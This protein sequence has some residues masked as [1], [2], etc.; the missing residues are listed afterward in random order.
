[1]KHFVT[2]ALLF[3]IGT[4]FPANAANPDH[5]RQLLDTNEC[6]RCDLR[7]ADLQGA[8]LQGADLTGANLFQ[9]N[10]RSADLRN[11]NLLMITLRQANLQSANLSQAV[12][13]DATLQNATLTDAVAIAIQAYSTNFYGVNATNANFE[14]AS[15]TN[16]NFG[17]AN[18]SGTNLRQA[19]LISANLTGAD[20]RTATLTDAN[21]ANTNLTEA[22]LPAW[23]WRDTTDHPWQNC[24]WKLGEQQ[25]LSGYP[26]GTFRPEN[27]VSR[28]EFAAMIRNAFPDAPTVRDATQFRDISSSYWGA[29]AIRTA[30]RTGFLSGYPGQVFR[31]NLNIPRVQV[32]VALASGLDLSISSNANRMLDRAFGQ[33]ADTIPDYAIP[34]T[35]AALE[36]HLV[37]KPLEAEF[38][39]NEPASRAEVAMSICQAR[40]QPGQVEQVPLQSLIQV[41]P[42]SPYEPTRNWKNAQL[43]HKIE[44]QEASVQLSHDGQ[45]LV[46]H[47][48]SN[49]IQVWDMETGELRQTI[50]TEADREV[51]AAAASPNGETVAGLTRSSDGRS[52]FLQIWNAQ[53]G[54]KARSLSPLEIPNPEVVVNK[55]LTAQLAYSPDGRFLASSISSATMASEPYSI[56]VLNPETGTLSQSLEVSNRAIETLE[57]APNSRTLASATGNDKIYLWDVETGQQQFVLKDRLSLLDPIDFS[58][59][60]QQLAVLVDGIHG[61]FPGVRIWDV[62]T[63]KSR[64]INTPFDRT[65][66]MHAINFESRVAIGASDVVGVEVVDFWRDRPYD[67]EGLAQGPPSRIREAVFSADGRAL[68][69]SAPEA[70]YVW[71]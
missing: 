48:D 34:K 10:S 59:D 28:V 56:Q 66:Q 35:A 11:A 15:L 51:V 62:E 52:L 60:S 23:M 21:L 47:N 71:R 32:L 29:D 33:T 8:D 30:N 50:S 69:V 19:N 12:L 13:R 31:P 26:D 46:T 36:E 70:V 68:V 37:I 2:S 4:A 14:S 22:Q 40:R 3:A 7:G 17:N 16:T 54:D 41:L 63:G 45:T 49:G 1:M 24:L 39:F 64:H 44:V 65:L 5:V 55:R 58:P 18:F 20:L 57:F 67:L 38:D 25:V 53:T 43:T 9:A 61:L 6:R 27:P 42:E